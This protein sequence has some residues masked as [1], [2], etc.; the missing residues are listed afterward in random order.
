MRR[1]QRGVTFLGWIFLLI[2]LAVVVYAVIRLVPVYLNYGRVA[3]S[4]AQIAEQAKADESTN[5]RSLT[6]SLDKRL[7]IE[8]IEFPTLKDFVI[9]RDGQ[10][11]VVEV[12]YEETIPFIYNVQ[13]LAT[14]KKTE[15]I[16]KAPSEP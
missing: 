15:R 5:A 1:N 7:D 8:G 3:K 13:L 4:M 16:G 2:P 6:N 14:F 9:R 10:S 12:N 11:W